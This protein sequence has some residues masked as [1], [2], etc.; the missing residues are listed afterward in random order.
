MSRITWW[1]AKKLAENLNF[2][3]GIRVVL[4]P[5]TTGSSHITVGVEAEANTMGGMVG[6]ATWATGIK[7]A[8]MGTVPELPIGGTRAAATIK[9]YFVSLFG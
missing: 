1:L 6:M 8:I 4:D 5:V 7:T 3:I 9:S 2:P